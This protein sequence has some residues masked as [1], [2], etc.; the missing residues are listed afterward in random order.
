LIGHWNLYSVAFDA[1]IVA[2]R[3]AGL[4][5]TGK[6]SA[7]VPVNYLA[8]SSALNPLALIVEDDNTLAAI[9]AEALR[10]AHFK[11]VIVLDGAV[12]LAQVKAF[13]PA[14]IILDLH[15]PH[16]SGVDILRQIRQDEQLTKMHVVVT[17]ADPV[18]AA[19][20]EDEADLVLIKP[21][22]LRQL[23][24]LARRIRSTLA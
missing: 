8:Q 13:A 1:L 15:L 3:V 20:V 5:L 6:D 11:S 14:L 9:Y 7:A 22:S 4:H 21:V 19:T 12:A 2:Q 17:T 16:V 23:R 10:Q 18:Q 24:D